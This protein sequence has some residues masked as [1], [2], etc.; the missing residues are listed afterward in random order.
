MTP[1]GLTGG[2]ASGKTT[3]CRLLEAKGCTII[4]ADVVAHQVLVRGQPGYEPVVQVFGTG[5]LGSAGEIDRGKLGAQVFGDPLL[6]ERLNKLVHPEVIR[7]IE[8]RLE[9][10]KQA[11]DAR[12]V[13]D[14]SL[15]IE[16]G[17][18]RRFQRLVLVTCTFE[19]QVERLTSRN[20]L[21]QEQA[22]QRIALQMPLDDKRPFATDIIDNSGPLEDTRLQVDALVENL[23]HTAWTTSH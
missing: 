5:I 7:I 3:V 21:S 16:S 11:A 4:D 12:V 2:I 13:V 14:A 10:L 17:F 1:V 6:L 20:G 23:E 15:M 8:K 9:T 18:H 22:R 19:Q